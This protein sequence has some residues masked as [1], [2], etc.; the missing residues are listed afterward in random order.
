MYACVTSA[1]IMYIVLP[2]P[3]WTVLVYS[4]KLNSNVLVYSIK[5]DNSVHLKIEIENFLFY[6]FEAHACPNA[7]LRTPNQR[8]QKNAKY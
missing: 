1:F 8:R 5:L 4:I 6:I 7:N 2:S 3:K